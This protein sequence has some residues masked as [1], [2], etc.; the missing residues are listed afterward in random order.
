MEKAADPTSANLYLSHIPLSYTEADVDALFHSKYIVMSLRLLYE[1]DEPGKRA[2]SGSKFRGAGFVRLENRAQA[3][4]CIA[5]LNGKLLPG[6]RILENGLAETLQ[7]RFADSDTQKWIKA[8]D[9]AKQRATALQKH[10]AISAKQIPPSTSP[11]ARQ[12]TM[13]LPPPL[14]V[15]TPTSSFSSLSPATPFSALLPQIKAVPALRYP[16]DV[17]SL[18]PLLFPMHSQPFVPHGPLR[19]PQPE[20]QLFNTI[21]ARQN[22]SSHPSNSMPTATSVPDYLPP[23]AV[24]SSAIPAIPTPPPA[25]N[26]PGSPDAH[27]QQYNPYQIA[28][29]IKYLQIQQLELQ[30]QTNQLQTHINETRARTS[31]EPSIT[32]A[33]TQK[34]AKDEPSI[35]SYNNA[36]EFSSSFASAS[37]TPSSFEPLSPPPSAPGRRL[38]EKVRNVETAYST[39]GPVVAARAR[40]H[41]TTGNPVRPLNRP[42]L[43]A[44]ASAL[45]RRS[46]AIEARIA[47]RRLSNSEEPRKPEQSTPNSK[48]VRS[49]AAS[50]DFSPSSTCSST[51]MYTDSPLTAR[52]LPAPVCQAAE[53]IKQK[54]I[55]PF[56]KD[57][58]SFSTLGLEHHSVLVSDKEETSSGWK[59]NVRRRYSHVGASSGALPG[60]Q[61]RTVSSALLMKNSFE[62]VTEAAE[63]LPSP[64]K[65]YTPSADNLTLIDLTFTFGTSYTSAPPASERDY[66]SSSIS[67]TLDTSQPSF[68]FSESGGYARKYSS[69]SEDVVDQFYDLSRHG[70]TP[71]ED[72]RGRS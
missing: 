69:A 37:S 57:L 49:P 5:E 40:S 59:N 51:S 28:E 55:L 26:E 15:D 58:R 18:A 50:S 35:Y 45:A 31:A 24:P 48:R 3:H 71:S 47:H 23:F 27:L 7:V 41:T 12:S 8:K 54:I 39:F 19:T 2:L 46:S 66:S 33:F 30:S 67:Q 65:Q 61:M 6:H 72:I 13:H 14:F 42:L 10:L 9:R 60:R 52:H 62:P 11:P 43:P 34:A 70:A 56:S 36:N 17:A 63:P 32:H 25:V 21:F 1:G 68:E 53:K 4:D 20:Q 64:V 16:Y 38:V 22:G 44:A 29:A